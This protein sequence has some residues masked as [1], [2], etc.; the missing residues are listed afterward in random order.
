MGRK[1]IFSNYIVDK[2]FQYS[3][4]LRN[5]LFLVFTLV[6]LGALI[7]GWNAIKFKQGFLLKLP[8]AEQVAQWAVENGVSSE[9]A[10]YTNQFILQAKPY[11]FVDLIWRPVIV[12][13]AADIIFLIIYGLYYSKKIAG[14]VYRLKQAMRDKIEG[15]KTERLIYRKSDPFHELE[16]LANKALE[17]ENNHANAK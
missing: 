1:L 5:I 2:E 13:L 16:E 10:E 4:I 14:P 3:F 6:F 17:L 11:T 12:V 15:R 8:P 7:V 9:S